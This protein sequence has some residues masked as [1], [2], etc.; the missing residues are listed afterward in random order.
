M[1]DQF[2]GAIKRVSVLILE[3]MFPNGLPRVFPVDNVFKIV[4]PLRAFERSF[5]TLNFKTIITESVGRINFDIDKRLI[6]C[7]QKNFHVV[8]GISAC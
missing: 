1:H 2:F 7:G 6:G 3:K 5:R 8:L 4:M